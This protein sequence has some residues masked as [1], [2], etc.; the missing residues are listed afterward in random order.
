MG[1][2]APWLSE[3]VEME[4]NITLS[5]KLRWKP[6]KLFLMQNT[7]SFTFSFHTR[8]EPVNCFC[9]HISLLLLMQLQN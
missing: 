2:E 8:K 4:A 1:V 6:F 7:Q 5:E 3:L 9:E